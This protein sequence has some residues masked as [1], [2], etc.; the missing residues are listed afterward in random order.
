LTV[1]DEDK[2]SYGVLRIDRPVI[3]VIGDTRYDQVWK[4]KTEAARHALIDSH[5]TNGRKIIVVGSSWKEDEKV[6]FQ[7]FRQLFDDIRELLVILVPHEPKEDNL[8]AIEK[9]MDGR[10][11]FIRFSHLQQ[12]ASEQVIIVD[13]VGILM[14]LYQYG[15][16]VYVGGGFGAGIH[17][18]LE[19]AVYGLPVLCG[20]RIHNSREALMLQ[21]SGAL[22]EILFSEDIYNRCRLLLT[23]E[24]ERLRCGAIALEI[25]KRNIGATT[26]FLSYLEKVL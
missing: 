9:E 19:P 23:D 17:N 22:F 12:Y 11:S 7:A 4:R 13:S 16:I 8:E 14:S 25:V 18:V 20:P 24:E 5:I 1:S 21:K 3:E 2:N 26:R 15:H 10:F 6:L